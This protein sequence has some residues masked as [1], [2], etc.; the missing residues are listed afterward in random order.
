M[1]LLPIGREERPI[2]RPWLSLGLVAL[3]VAAFVLM[4][5]GTD[6]SR[7]LL[8]Q[9]Q[10]RTFLADHPDLA[11][12]ADLARWFDQDDLATL[13]K[14]RSASVSRPS[15]AMS[16]PDQEALDLLSRRLREAIDRLPHHL[17]GF[18]PAHARATTLVTYMFVHAGFWHLFGNMIFLWFTAPFLEELL[19]KPAFAALYLVS[20]LAAAAFH[21]LRFPD[22]AIP[23]VG[24]SG[25]I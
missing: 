12:P 18:V 20:G 3:N 24:A 19:G 25:A 11:P 14:T 10:L 21:A 17:F 1:L 4:W 22:S 7:V 5:L 23:L 15:A 8:R 9:G 13:G 2:R 16:G 6:E